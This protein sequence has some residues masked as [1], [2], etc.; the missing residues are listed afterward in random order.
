MIETNANIEKQVEP[1]HHRK[2]ELE[3]SFADLGPGLIPG[4][5]DFARYS[6][7]QLVILGNSFI[8]NR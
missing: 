7:F 5:T 1:K 3:G 6:L 2:V 4:A 8:W